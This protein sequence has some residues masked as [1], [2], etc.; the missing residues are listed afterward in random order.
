MIRR[1]FNILIPLVLIVLF[2]TGCPKR[3]LAPVPPVEKPPFVNPIDKVLEILSFAETLQAKASIR[4]DMVR[5]AEK[6]V[7]LLNG[8]V[9]YQGPD[10][11]RILGYHPLG[12]GLFDALYRN[13]EFSLLLPLQKMAF[14]GEVSQFDDAMR[15]VGEIQITSGKNEMRNIPNRI[16]INIVEKQIEID[17]RMKEIQVNQELPEDTFQWNLPE[18]VEVR[19]LSRLLRGIK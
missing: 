12:M 7:F 10:R 11:L 2:I 14:T 15:K 8:V 16:W 17:L 13:G 3:P 6:Q 18:G 9:L 1:S 4:I 5:D 19:P